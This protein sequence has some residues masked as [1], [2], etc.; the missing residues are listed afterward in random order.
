MRGLWAAGFALCAARADAQ[1]IDGHGDVPPPA[2]PSSGPV[3]TWAP[4]RD[5]GGSWSVGVLAEFA[6]A[7]VVQIE[8][9][10]PA[11]E[12]RTAVL[13]DV[14]GLNVGGVWVPHERVGLAV[15]LPVFL[16][17]ADDFGATTRPALGDLHVWVP[18]AL[19]GA[20]A[21]RGFAL[22]VVPWA[23][24]PTGAA[25]EWLGSGNVR[26]GLL[27][28]PGLRAGPLSAALHGGVEAGPSVVALGTTAGGL[29]ARFGA[30]LG[31]V[32]KDVALHAEVKGARDLDAGGRTPV[33]AVLSVDGRFGGAALRAAGGRGLTSAPGTAAVRGLIG[34]AWSDGPEAEVEVAP[35]AV[36]TT[37]EVRGPDD[38][39]VMGAAIRVDGE[40]VGSTDA[41]GRFAGDIKWRR[42]VTVTA[43]GF[44]ATEVPAPAEGVGEVG[45]ALAWEPSRVPVR[46]TDQEG[47][48]VAARVAATS[49]AGASV[50]LVDGALA[51]TP[52]QWTVEVLSEGDGRQTRTV[53]VDGPGAWVPEVEVVVRRIGGAA[54][55]V[56]TVADA[57][58]A[59]I[60]EARVLVDGLPMG[61]T[62][63]GGDARIDGLAPGPHTLEVRHDAFTARTAADIALRIGDNR[64]DVV[65]DRVPGSVRVLVRGP[66]ARP[67]GDATVRFDGPTRLPPVPVGPRGER[68]QVLSP[69]NWRVLVLSPSMGTQAR[70]VA[71]TDTSHRMLDV[72][73]ILQPVEDGAAE[74]D[75]AVVDPDGHA[76]EGVE[77]QL[78][79]RSYGATAGGVLRLAGLGPGTR[80]LSLASPHHRPRAT[81]EIGLDSGLQAHVSVVEWLPGSV[82][83][84]VRGADGPVTDAT[85]RF[86]GPTRLDPI[87]AGSKG[88]V[89][90]RV[91]PG[92]W[93]VIALSAAGGLQQRAVDVPADG[94]TLQR[95]EVVFGG[96]DGLARLEVE[97]LDPDGAPVS[98]AEVFV[99][100]EPLGT[101]GNMGGLVAE[102]LPIGS[103]DIEVR[104]PL[105]A[106]LTR[107]LRLLE[108]NQQHELRLTWATGVVRVAAIGAGGPAADA[109]VR[110]LGPSPMAA[111]PV[112][113]AGERVLPLAPGRWM[114]VALSPTAG[115]AQTTVTVGEADPP[116]R[117]ALQ[118][119]A[120]EEGVARLLLRVV[121]E[122]GAPVAG[123][124]VNFR[125][126]SVGVTEVGGALMLDDLDP[127]VASVAVEAAGFD[128]GQ[129][130]FRL[131][132]GA[133]E[134]I[135]ALSWRPG[136]VSVA[137]QDEA[138]A[139][140]DA[141]VRFTGPADRAAERTGGD[142][143]VDAALRPGKWHVVASTATL[144]PARA[145]VVVAPG[146]TRA[147]QLV[148]S[149]SKVEMA[150]GVMSIKEE[151]RFDFGKDTLRG[152]A[153]A[154]L[155]Q[156]ANLLIGHADLAKVIVEGHTD[157][158][159]DLAYNHALSQR[160]ADAVVRALV[161]RG[162]AREL[163]VARG[164]GAQRPVADNTTEEGR[165]LNR[166]VAFT[167]EAAAER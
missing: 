109:V 95:V 31:L 37:L 92:R 20:G 102:R 52:G 26:G 67:V 155:A 73:V 133:Q 19:A 22:S 93:T 144:G 48:K 82:R 10:G 69:G 123:A 14:F 117:V 151:I 152:D 161:A 64:S 62:S 108:G 63:T 136:T 25:A 47:R 114:L 46:V 143:R 142:G 7:P 24:L 34:L 154:L 18:V 30:A 86:V 41:A 61:S 97:V 90:T 126:K 51:L 29:D 1:T 87:A 13:D 60:P 163:L 54:S 164:Y 150:H 2:M 113:A 125:G 91:P 72:E 12:E 32:F 134:R 165:A 130:D 68:V 94:R 36:L 121:D 43:P 119:T 159:G 21:A 162:V 27:A 98:G 122:A 74:L 38:A 65:L 59:P 131:V 139:P 45:V 141:E 75:L 146:G 115:V 105:Y 106:P 55:L 120:A 100:D 158:V 42:G 4:L 83:V 8:T 5:A 15:T 81:E 156:V 140:V 118:L 107:R 153:D 77:V 16:H 160:R 138:G 49:Q 129:A 103:R 166:R 6:D 167:V 137:V 127:G 23:D 35:R 111:M 128:P 110:A 70:D 33:E 53:V 39:P 3:T 124:S 145:E 44:V 79:E 116:R 104:A 88:T 11:E 58:G 85:V 40:E 84:D 17:W 135:V 101:T 78:D 28:V 96:A 80:T 149:T 50:P 89:L 99:D 157:N 112:D 71:V 147:V 9:D 76:V 56:A 66:D 148:L 132:D 57:D